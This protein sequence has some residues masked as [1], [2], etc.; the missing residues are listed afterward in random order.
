MSLQGVS[1]CFSNGE[2]AQIFLA[3]TGEDGRNK[4]IP[5]GGGH[6]AMGLGVGNLSA[7]GDPRTAVRIGNDLVLN[8]SMAVRTLFLSDTERNMDNGRLRYQP[9]LQQGTIVPNE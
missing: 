6:C 9:G 1:W 5:F 2:N 3:A 4:Y 7:P 8:G